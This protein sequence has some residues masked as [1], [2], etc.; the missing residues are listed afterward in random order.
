VILAGEILG[1]LTMRSMQA[2]VQTPGALLSP[3]VAPSEASDPKIVKLQDL[4]SFL[5]S[6]IFGQ[7]EAIGKVSAALLSAE[8]EL[9]ETGLHPRASFLFMGPTGV[10]KTETAKR[11]TEYLFDDSKLEM[12]FMNE[13]QE[14]FKV[15]DLIDRLREGL[16]RN[17]AGTTL[18]FDEI[19]KAHPK[20]IDLFLSMLDEGQVTVDASHRLSVCNCYVVMTSNIGSK[21]FP[22]MENSKYQTLQDF[23]MAEA[24]KHLRPEMIARLSETIVYRPLKQETQIRILNS[25]ILRKVAHLERVLKIRLRIDEKP[26]HAHLLRVGF[27]ITGGARFIRQEIDRQFNGAVLPWLLSDRKPD[28]GMFRHDPRAGKLVLE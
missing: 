7:E 12:F 2:L 3:A 21:T 1:Q 16:K 8:F 24:R 15:A 26:V 9:N 22:E 5:Q 10:G 14:S 17:P 25:L 27:N 13:Y 18:L 11:F 28:H 23:A 4:E 6:R 20:I 19:E